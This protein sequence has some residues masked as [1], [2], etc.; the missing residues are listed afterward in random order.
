MA[1]NVYNLDDEN[2]K[3]QYNKKADGKISWWRDTLSF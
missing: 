2:V 3:T 1:V